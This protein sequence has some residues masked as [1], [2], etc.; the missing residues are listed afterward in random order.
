MEVT[1]PKYFLNM[2]MIKKQQMLLKIVLFLT[3]IID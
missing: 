2:I 3:L 1:Y